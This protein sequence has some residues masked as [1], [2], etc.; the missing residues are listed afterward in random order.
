[1]NPGFESI[2]PWLDHLNYDW[3]ILEECGDRVTY[4]LHEPV[5]HS[6]D[7][8]EFIYIVQAGRIQLFLTTDNGKEK[9]VAIVGAN[10]LIGENYTTQ[11]ISYLENTVAVSPSTLL[12]VPRS[13]FEKEVLS[14]PSLAKQWID[15]L[16]QKLRLLAISN[17]QL[18]FGNSYDLICHAL[19]HLAISYGKKNTDGITIGITFTHQEL[20]NLIGTSRVTVANTINQMLQNHILSKKGKYYHI[21]SLE[22]LTTI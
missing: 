17:L 8:A 13:L 15:M 1:M 2:S 6:G 21:Q 10:G 16:N 4:R 11:D 3:S 5:Y 14:D 7:P 18:S 12:R 19:Y 9:S 20:A 22:L